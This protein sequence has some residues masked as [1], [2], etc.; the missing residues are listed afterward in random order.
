MEIRFPEA[1]D[2]EQVRTAH[3]EM[4]HQGFTFALD[5]DNFRDF[6]D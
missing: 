1:G 5:L 3:A 4:A 2:E 6:D